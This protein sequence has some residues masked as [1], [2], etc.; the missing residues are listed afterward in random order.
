MLKNINLYVFWRKMCYLRGIYG[1]SLGRG[2]AEE[3]C[4]KG[5]IKSVH[6]QVFGQ[7]NDVFSTLRQKRSDKQQ[8]FQDIN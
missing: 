7:K 6:T 1:A 2:G 4:Y 8:P 3:S 5:T